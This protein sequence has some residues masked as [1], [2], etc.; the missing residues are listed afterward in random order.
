M[1]NRRKILLRLLEACGGELN[2]TDMEKLLFLYC[3]EQGVNYYDFFPYKF[4]CFSFLSYQDKRVMTQQ[5]YLEHADRFKLKRRLRKTETLKAG[6]LEQI[7]EFVSRTKQL[8]GNALVRHVYIHY[9]HVAIRSEIKEKLLSRAEL[10]EVQKHSPI[11]KEQCLMTIGYEGLT[12]DAYVNKLIGNNVAVVVDVRR[13][14]IS[15]KYGFSKTRLKQYL[16]GVEI[17]YEHIPELGIPS[18]QRKNL[19]TV[20]DYRRLFRNYAAI[21]LPNR[22][23]ELQKIRELL[24]QHKRVALTCFEE[25]PTSCHRHKITERLAKEKGWKIPI[26]H[27]HRLQIGVPPGYSRPG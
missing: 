23:K 25:S 5:G 3:A 17:S 16:E 19:E 4:G 15:M 6:E 1:F 2:N 11:D 10:A 14:P 9:P 18:S 21:A 8:R 13:N 27:I 26:H 20:N 7:K 22:D 24:Q 12:I